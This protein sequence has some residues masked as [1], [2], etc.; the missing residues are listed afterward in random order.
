MPVRV[1]HATPGQKAQVRVRRRHNA[2]NKLW[3]SWNT[4]AAYAEREGLKSAAIQGYVGHVRALGLLVV[5]PHA[6]KTRAG[7][8]V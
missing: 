2:R 7:S 1:W 4:G 8:W 3:F 6:F 5:C